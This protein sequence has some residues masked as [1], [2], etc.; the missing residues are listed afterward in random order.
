[1]HRMKLETTLVA[2]TNIWC[3]EGSLAMSVKE[4]LKMNLQRGIEEINDFKRTVTT[5]AGNVTRCRIISTNRSSEISAVNYTA[6]TD[7]GDR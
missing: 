5:T 1:M 2:V 4:E 6:H 3:Q 7:I